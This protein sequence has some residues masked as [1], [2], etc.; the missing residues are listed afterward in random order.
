MNIRRVISALVVGV[1]V[2]MGVAA[3]VGAEPGD[4]A[5]AL[6]GK[7]EARYSALSALGDTWRGSL[8]GDLRGLIGG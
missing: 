4:R 6:R 5:G 2:G 8:G 1:L 3:S 7:A